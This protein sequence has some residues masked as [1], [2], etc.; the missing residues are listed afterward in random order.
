MSTDQESWILAQNGFIAEKALSWEGLLTQGSGY[1]HI[2][3]SFEETLGNSPQNIEY[4]RSADNVSAEKF[5][6]QSTKWGTYIPGIYGPVPVYVSEI[7]NMP[8]CLGIDLYVGEE[9][10]RRRK[11]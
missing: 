11:T 10:H 8:Y 9:R 4:N 6:K 2:R 5:V 1:L 3:G 7:T